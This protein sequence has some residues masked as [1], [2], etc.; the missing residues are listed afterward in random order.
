M[1]LP[2]E[3]GVV[4]EQEAS[5]SLLPIADKAIEGRS[6]GRIAWTRLKRDKVAM[7][8]AIV[9]V[10]IVIVAIFGP[11]IN[12]IIGN[13]PNRFNSDLISGDT[14][15]PYG[16]FGGSTGSHLLGI[17][18]VNGRDIL[19]RLI[20]GT[21]ISIFISL[22]SMALSLVFGLVVGISAG[23]YRGV[24]DSVLARVMDLLLAF[25]TLL[26]SIALLSIFNSSPSFLG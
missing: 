25:P 7:G 13:Q 11:L 4:A 9:I 22:A 10:L 23:F 17:E 3:L 18:P 24:V 14:D 20:A 26:F 6:L 2:T 21:R 15:L 1:T 19:A 12:D 5:A 8:G 16:S